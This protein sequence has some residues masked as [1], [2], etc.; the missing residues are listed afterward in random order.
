MSPP[1]A[2]HPVSRLGMRFYQREFGVGELAGFVQHFRR[3]RH[4][5][6][7]V[8][9]ACKSRVARLLP[10]QPQLL[11]QRDHQRANGH[12]MHVSIV[13]SP[14]EP[15]DADERA[16]IAQ[17]RIVYFLDQVHGIPRLDRLAHARFLEHRDYRLPGLAADPGRAL[18]FLR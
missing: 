12:G 15:G 3:N 7:I 9:Q 11:R 2:Q 4:F 5:S 14:L 6:D 13:V 1:P 10:V 18:D 17:H 8:Q 16:R